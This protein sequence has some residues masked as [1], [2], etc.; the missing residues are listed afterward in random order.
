MSLRGHVSIATLNTR[1]T[2]VRGSQLADRYRSIG[3]FFDRSDVEIVNFQEVHTYHHLRLL[4]TT[5][6]SYG[7]SF[8]PSLAGPAGGVAT[9]V[10]RS[11]GTRDYH[12]LSIGSGVSRWSRA[13]AS[14]KGVLL[15]RLDEL[16]IANTHLLAN[17]DGDWSDESRFTPIHRGQ[18]DALARVMESTDGPLVL[19]GDFNVARKST[20][21]KAFLDRTG[22][23][24][25]FD[26]RCPP[27]FHAEYLSPGNS[28][29]CIDFILS[30]GLDVQSAEQILTD[31][32]HL[33][34]GSMY[35]SDHV[36]LRVTVN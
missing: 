3:A 5:M 11:A 34:G 33:P 29:H 19:C 10:R 13:K 36:G 9:F 30:R 24:D 35:V 14:F 16:W 4:R 1:G 26:G 22:L 18:L 32:V 8:R 28:P 7:V 12:R 31:K 23:T 21:Y 6:P 25:A 20:P 2:P 27:T 15:T 17:T